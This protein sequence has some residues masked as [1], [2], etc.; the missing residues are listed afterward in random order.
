[1][2]LRR[3]IEEAMGRFFHEMGAQPVASVAKLAITSS[4]LPPETTT[5]LL[6]SRSKT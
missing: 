6:E 3:G 2:E 4:N 5:I 1:M